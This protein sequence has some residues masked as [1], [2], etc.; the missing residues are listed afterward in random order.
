MP[1]Q[2]GP[3]C[4]YDPSAK[5]EGKMTEMSKSER[6][7]DKKYEKMKPMKK[8]LPNTVLPFAPKGG[9]KKTPKKKQDDISYS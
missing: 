1:W 4:G 5:D 6:I 7:G 3:K 2:N 8:K 9:E